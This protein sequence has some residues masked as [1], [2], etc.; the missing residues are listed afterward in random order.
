MAAMPELALSTPEWEAAPRPV[1]TVEIVVPVYNEAAGL[2]P[3][4]RRL[5]AY[6]NERF[7]LTWLVTIVDNASTDGT[8]A[9]ARCLAT[10]LDGVQARHLDRKGRGRALRA[11]WSVS[12]ASVVA[13]MDVDLSTDLNALLPLVAPL[14]SG[15]SDIAIG[16]RLAP[17][18]DVVRGPKREASSRVYNL[19]LKAAVVPGSPTPSAASRRSGPTS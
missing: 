8:W 6:L 17:G 10:E 19:L 1:A 16:T 4:I 11:A 14:V 3:S 7:P 15:H 12:T 13:Y 18:A 5:Y 9:I 2:E